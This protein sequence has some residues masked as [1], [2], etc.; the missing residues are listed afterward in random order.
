MKKVLIVAV[1]VVIIALLGIRVILGRQGVSEASVAKASILG[2]SVQDNMDKGVLITAVHAN[3]LAEQRGLQLN[4]AIVAINDKPV[5][6]QRHYQQILDEALMQKSM[7]FLIRRDSGEIRIRFSM[8]YAALYNNLGN[9]Y[10]KDKQYDRAIEA[11][12]EAL[13]V[14]PEF[15]EGYYNLGGVYAQQ[16]KYDLA[17]EHY[18]KAI[19]YRGNFR[20]AYY[21]LAEVYDKQGN[22]KDAI[23]TYKSVLQSS[24]SDTVASD[25]QPVEVVHTARGEI[26]DQLKFSGTIEPRSRVIVFPKA[27]GVLEKMNVDQGDMVRKD[28]ILAVV[29]HEE[30]ELQVRQAEA[31][32]MAAQAGYDQAVQLAKIRVMSQVEQARAGLEASEAA[33]QQVRDLAETRSE[34]QIQQ[35]KAALDALKANLEKIRRGA[36]EEEREQVRATVAQAEANLSNVQNNYDRMKRLF[37]AGAI[38]KQTYDGAKTQLDVAKAQSQAAKEQWNMVEEGAREEDIQ[39]M[40]AQVKQAEA[41]FTLAQRQSEKQTW[42]KDIAMAEARVKQARAA[43]KSAEILVQAKSWEAE[44][45]A[46]E[47]QLVQ[48]RT[49][50]DL[51]RKQLAD[52]SVKSPIK[53]IVSIRHLDEGS[54]VSPAAPIFEVVDVDELHADVEVLESD[55]AK[56][57]LGDVAWIHVSALDD[58]V[59]SRVTSISPTVDDESRTAKVEI[60]IDNPDHLLK[61]G[62][63]AQ[64]FVPIDVRRAAVLLPKDAVIENEANGERYVFVADSGRSRKTVIEYGL[65]EGNLVEIVKGLDVGVPVIIAGQQNLVDGDFVQVV[66]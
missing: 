27:A 44:I 54:M 8:E 57:H 4:D 52:A 36:R 33:L 13:K 49:M 15:A 43:L 20:E 30:L 45:T 61:P 64:V 40:E 5:E 6:N 24:P 63:F 25:L 14:D 29:E 23:Q 59:K 22:H 60:T 46:A 65:M 38:S 41:A 11:Y 26:K 16:K 56:I 21:K 42:Q 51:S 47:T 48:A 1:V 17:I 50:R 28:Q 19:D 10:I 12:Q 3:S 37:D 53:G 58:A 55:L 66:N 32:V 62:M 2:I 18:K 9:A 31:A 34:T 7:N 39:A 35:A